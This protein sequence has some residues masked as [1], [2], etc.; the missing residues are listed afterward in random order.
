MSDIRRLYVA[1]GVRRVL[2]DVG[3]IGTGRPPRRWPGRWRSVA[4]GAGAAGV[5]QAG[6]C[7]GRLIVITAYIVAIF[8]VAASVT[9]AT[10]RIATSRARDFL[11]VPVKRD[12]L[13]PFRISMHGRKM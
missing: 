11:H 8:R 4:S 10:R 7:K 1:V 3:D 9:A 2:G 13:F 12:S 6:T 5:R